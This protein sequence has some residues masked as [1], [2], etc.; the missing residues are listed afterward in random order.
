MDVFHLVDHSYGHV[1]HFLPAHRTGIYCHDLDAL[2]PLTAGSAWTLSTRALARSVLRALCRVAVVFYSS[3]PIRQEILERGLLDE[4]KL[5]YAPYGVAPEFG[6]ADTPDPLVDHG[7]PPGPFLLHVGSGAPRKRLDLLFRAFA[8]L[9]QDWPTLFLVQQGAKLT[10]EQQALLN[11]LGIGAAVIRFPKL[12]RASLAHLYRRAKLVVLPSEREGFGLPLIESLSCGTPVLVRDLPV[13]R[14]VGG[15][16]AS[17]CN[18]HEPLGWATAIG[19]RLAIPDSPEAIAQRLEQA[20]L[21]SWSKHAQ[22]I[23]NTYEAL[24]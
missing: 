8:A 24:A 15:R 7:L 23:L 14:E 12:P 20:A 21:F 9:R 5:V 19:E 4:R 13:L 22:T 3:S 11:H 18:E 16:A 17:Y 2:R 10:R 1:A 6:P